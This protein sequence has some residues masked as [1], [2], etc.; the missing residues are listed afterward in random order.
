MPHANSRQKKKINVNIARFWTGA[1]FEAIKN[2]LLQ[3]LEEFYEFEVSNQPSV[4]LYGPYP[5]KLPDGQ[6]IKVFIGCENVRPIMRECD[7]AFGVQYEETIDSQ[8][9]MRFVGWGDQAHL[10]QGP[11]NDW[12][13]V[14]K[15]KER[16]CA[17]LYAHRVFY[18]DAFFKA[19][20]RYK[21]VDAPGRAM[22]NMA[23]IDAGPGNRNSKI[24]FLKKYKFVIAF[25]NSSF[26]GYNTEKLSD[27]IEADTMPIYWG[28]PQIG[29]SFNVKRFINA[30]NFVRE[31]ERFLPR[32]SYYTHS[33]DV[34]NDMLLRRIARRWDG[35]CGDLEQRIWALGGFS[36]LIDEIIRIDQDDSLYLEHLQQPFLIGNALPDRK[37]WI[38]RWRQIFESA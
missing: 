8:R 19:L 14:L 22:N 35:T 9:Y 6:Y 34:T 25:E 15:S 2:L 30:H 7:W 24:E 36:K 27:A 13:A 32:F 5:G 28:D 21:S 23:P 18:R 12:A 38:S 20:S 4:V 26:P 16:F 11:N 1:T 31:P 33:T 10:I 3:N 37:A 29:R 17:F